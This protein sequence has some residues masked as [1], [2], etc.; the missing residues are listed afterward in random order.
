MKTKNQ[1]NECIPSITN[2]QFDELSLAWDIVMEM[3]WKTP[4]ATK[5]ELIEKEDIQVCNCQEDSDV[6]FIYAKVCFV[7]Y[8]LGMDWD[9]DAVWSWIDWVNEL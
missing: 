4:R 7:N 3:S 5:V 6:N 8:L 9:E 2:K 1:P